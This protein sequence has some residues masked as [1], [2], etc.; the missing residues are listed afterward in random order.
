MYGIGL[1]CINRK[2]NNAINGYFVATEFCFELG[3]VCSRTLLAKHVREQY[4]K[5]TCTSRKTVLWMKCPCCVASFRRW[6]TCL[7]HI[8]TEE[9]S[10]LWSGE[11]GTEARPM[12]CD[13]NTIQSTFIC[14]QY[15]GSLNQIYLHLCLDSGSELTCKLQGKWKWVVQVE[16]KPACFS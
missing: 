4:A 12:S 10:Q 15:T 8:V 1:T 7:F 3:Q 14:L 16:L 6:G 2:W 11:S 5:C 13:P 9:I